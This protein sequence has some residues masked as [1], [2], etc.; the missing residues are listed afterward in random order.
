VDLTVT[1]GGAVQSLRKLVVPFWTLDSQACDV[2]FDSATTGTK[3]P[4]KAQGSEY[5]VS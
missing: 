5:Q 3:R 1:S 2:Q 4:C